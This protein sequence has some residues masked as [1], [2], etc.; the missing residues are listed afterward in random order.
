MTFEDSLRPLRGDLNRALLVILAHFRA[1]IGT[2]H[3]LEADGLLHLR[4]HTPGIPE[5]VLEATRVIPIGKGIAGL[6]VERKEP[7][8]LCNLQQDAT[9][10]VRPGA[11][12]TQAMGSICVPMFD[13]DRAVGALGI[14]TMHERTFQDDEIAALVAAGRVLVG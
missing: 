2:I 13:G 14:A 3:L 5:P 1:Q 4:A 7:I 12:A 9:G 8:N 6:A 11:R 10:D